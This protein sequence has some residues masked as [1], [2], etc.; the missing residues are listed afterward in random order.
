MPEILLLISRWIAIFALVVS[1]LLIIL[2]WKVPRS[3]EPSDS[4]FGW[5]DALRLWRRS[6]ARSRERELDIRALRRKQVLII[7]PD[8][9]SAKVLMWRL[10][11]LGCLVTRTKSGTRGL[12]AVRT[13]RPDVVIADA[14]LPDVPAADVYSALDGLPLVFIR[15]LKSQRSEFAAMGTGVACLGKPFDPEETVQTAGALLRR[16]AARN[17]TL[18]QGRL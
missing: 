12:E 6:A 10:E 1:V 9:K 14:L 5:R 18:Q 3:P 15:A 8:E 17:L 4:A 13:A 2:R 16:S 7:D 11:G